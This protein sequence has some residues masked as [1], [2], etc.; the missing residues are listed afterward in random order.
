M[1]GSGKKASKKKSAVP[2]AS[3]LTVTNDFTDNIDKLLLDNSTLIKD[4][5]ANLGMADAASF[6]ANLGIMEQFNK[7]TRQVVTELDRMKGVSMPKFPLTVDM[8][9]WSQER[10][11]RE[12]GDSLKETGA[13]AV[14][15][16]KF[17]PGMKW[18]GKALEEEKA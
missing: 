2:I 11:E 16:R 10:E 1:Y 4:M 18:G 14:E 9:L 12:A 5:R 15:G 13:G 3:K 17:M 6:E 7:M 8:S